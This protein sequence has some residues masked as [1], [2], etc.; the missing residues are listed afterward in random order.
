MNKKIAKLLIF[1]ALL[2]FS[3]A[4]AELRDPTRPEVVIQTSAASV[5]LFELNAILIAKDRKIAVINGLNLKIGD[6]ILGEHITAINKNTV[7]LSGP[8]GKITLFLLDKNVKKLSSY[9]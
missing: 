7:Q 2:P 6:P 1:I 4:Y 5:K 3:L 9:R 8:G